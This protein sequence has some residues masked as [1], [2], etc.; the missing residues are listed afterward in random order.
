MFT[1]YHTTLFGSTSNNTTYIVI[2]AGGK[3]ST[4]Q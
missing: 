1:Q 3:G 2:S 4:G